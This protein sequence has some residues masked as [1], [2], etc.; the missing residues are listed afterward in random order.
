MKEVLPD[1][2]TYNHVLNVHALCGDTERS[3]A[4]VAEL[5]TQMV[6]NGD[7]V[8]LSPDRFTFT[9]LIKAYAAKQ[10]LHGTSENSSQIAADAT[11]V[12]QRMLSL[13]EAGWPNLSPSVVT[14]KFRV[15]IVTSRFE[16]R[17]D[18]LIL[19]LVL[20]TTH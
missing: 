11:R 18:Q 1:T 17:R 3:E 16:K 6:K 10:R 12:F 2:S 7:K 14:C 8:D 20:Q 15:D 9:T 13:S 5:E 19:S 4:L